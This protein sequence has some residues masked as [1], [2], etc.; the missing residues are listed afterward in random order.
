M[1]TKSATVT[2]LQLIS[3]PFQGNYTATTN[4]SLIEVHN[5]VVT[6]HWFLNF[7][8]VGICKLDGSYVFRFDIVGFNGAHA[9]LTFFFSSQDFCGQ[10]T[11]TSILGRIRT[12][13]DATYTTPSTI[14]AENALIYLWI[15]VES[16]FTVTAVDVMDVAVNNQT[17]PAYGVD[18]VAQTY[19]GVQFSM[20]ALIPPFQIDANLLE[21]QVQVTYSTPGK[22]RGDNNQ[23]ELVKVKKA[24]GIKQAP[25][26]ASTTGTATT[27]IIVDEH[28]TTVIPPE[29]VQQQSTKSGAS[30]IHIDMLQLI[31]IL[32]A[33]LLAL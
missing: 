4:D 33:A 24:V 9:D 12:F 7:Y 17:Y 26:V 30:S 31:A 22:K 2:N 5:G 29:N 6:Q 32:F 28:N 14:F 8:P 20:I 27:G 13:S 15:Q 1:T 25:I 23:P 10:V 18:N 3:S 19:F 11:N 16:A 21:F